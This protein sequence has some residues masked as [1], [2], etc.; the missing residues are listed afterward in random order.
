MAVGSRIQANF[1]FEFFCTDQYQ[2]SMPQMALDFKIDQTSMSPAEVGKQLFI[3]S[4]ISV[5]CTKLGV[6]A[7]ISAA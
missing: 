3:A 4:Y 5:L 6:C 1:A 7:A 2:P